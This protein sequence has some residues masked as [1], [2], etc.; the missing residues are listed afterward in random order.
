MGNK[1][2][3]DRLD[4]RLFIN[5]GGKTVARIAATS[6]RRPQVLGLIGDPGKGSNLQ[7]RD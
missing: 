3:V 1:A 2:A 5:G 7:P 4:E 6:K